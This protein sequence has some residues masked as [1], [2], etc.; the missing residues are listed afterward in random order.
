MDEAASTGT[1]VALVDEQR[2]LG[3]VLDAAI[4]MAA[5]APGT[6]LILFDAS[7][8][9]RPDD[10]AGQTGASLYSPEELEQLERPE[11]ARQVRD[12]RLRGIDTWAS[13][14]P[15]PGLEPMMEFARS[16]GAD[17]VLLPEELGDPIVL[18]RLR[19]DAPVDAEVS[20]TTSILVVPKQAP[21]V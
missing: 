7:G 1:I 9:S 10:R 16:C 4:E 5:D 18:E 14:F 20:A 21:Q 8:A 19:G 11:I 17:V 13:L 12:A 2:D 6:R 3:Y 15:V